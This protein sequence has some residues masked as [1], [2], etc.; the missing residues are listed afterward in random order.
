MT[1]KQVDI[2]IHKISHDLNMRIGKRKVEH[3]LD[4]SKNTDLTFSDLLTSIQS[5]CE[6]YGIGAINPNV[7]VDEKLLITMSTPCLLFFSKEKSIYIKNNEFD[8]FQAFEISIDKKNFIPIS[9][10]EVKRQIKAENCNHFISFYTVKSIHSESFKNYTDHKK[11]WSLL[12]NLIKV[13]RQ[14]LYYVIIYS[15]LTG[16]L[17]LSLPLGVQ[18]VLNLVSSG[19]MVDTIYYLI[20]LVVLGSLIGGG[21]QIIQFTLLEKL[22]QKMFSRISF[23]FAF[24]LPRFKTEVFNNRYAP[25]LMNRFFEVITIQKSFSK[26][27]TDFFASALQIIFGLALLAF[28]HPIF[29]FFSVILIAL[30]VT[31]FVMSSEI[32][33]KTNLNESKYK[34]KIVNWL[35]EASRTFNAIKL[36]GVPGF[37]TQ[38]LNDLNGGYIYSRNSHFKI[39]R[40]Q[41]MSILLFKSIIT[42]TLLVLGSVLVVQREITLGQFVA[43][44]IVII[45]V[46][47]AADKIV[48]FLEII[49]D[50]LVSVLKIGEIAEL[51]LEK[52]TGILPSRVEMESKFDIQMVDFKYHFP[53]SKDSYLKVDKLEIKKGEKIAILGEYSSGKSTFLNM[54]G[55][56]SLD[57]EGIYTINHISVKQMNLNFLR[58]LIGE[59]LRIQDVFEGTILENITLNNVDITYQDIIDTIHKLELDTY[60]NKQPEGIETHVT[61]TGKGLPSSVI[62]KIILAR[63]IVDKPS[64]LLMDS[65]FT[66]PAEKSDLKLYDYIL[67]PDLEWTVLGVSNSVHFASRC[68]RLLLFEKG[69]LVKDVHKSNEKEF[70]KLI[71]DYTL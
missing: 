21:L 37:A 4:Y 52:N 32:G 34:Y 69:K 22:K 20:A 48:Q 59:N 36:S 15:L 40:L 70:T 65:D 26:I 42:G 43:S 57:Y 7:E 38:K 25:E 18:A 9:Y 1:N 55:G 27:F 2:L 54:V 12:F 39:L 17:T 14:D 66:T 31:I 16:V 29:I 41:Y 53:D 64:L 24:K 10:N 8:N 13:E 60:I 62:K 49:Y 33:L 6:E 44:E 56:T 51:P 28:Y 11:A 19:M 30:L 58:T 61:A 71:L 63:S 50:L 35:E 45:L 47:G 5:Q 68:E 3:L 23:D 46:I 67:S